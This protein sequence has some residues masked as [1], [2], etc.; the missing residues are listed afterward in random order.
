MVNNNIFIEGKNYYERAYFGWQNKDTALTGLIM[1]YKNS[2]D[3]L[4]E[5]A[6]ENGYGGDIATLDTYI[7]P[8]FFMYRHAIEL[9]IKKIYQRCYGNIPTGGH[10]LIVLWD[11]VT[12][13]VLEYFKKEA[14]LNEIKRSK[15]RFIKFKIDDKDLTKIRLNLLEISKVDNKSDTF[16]YLMSND[17]ELYFTNSKFIDYKHMKE[18]IDGLLDYL[19]FLYDVTDE[20]LSS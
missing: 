15:D 6:L 20:Y 5:I 18:K 7:F 13:E 11:K 3:D 14:V 10:D 17:G 2:A 9:S 1:G 4:V 16:R 19:E 8:I 12:K